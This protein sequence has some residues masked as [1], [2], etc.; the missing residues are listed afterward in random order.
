[1]GCQNSGIPCRIVLFI[2]YSLLLYTFY[3]QCIAAHLPKK[4]ISESIVSAHRAITAF[5][6][7]T[8]IFVWANRFQLQNNA[9]FIS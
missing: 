3:S 4:H 9:S 8:S 1:M 5:H 2:A 7:R 6:D